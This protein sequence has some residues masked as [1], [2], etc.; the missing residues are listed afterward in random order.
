VAIGQRA[1]KRVCALLTDMSQPLGRAAGNAVEVAECVA[2]LRGGGPEDL[3]QLTLELGARML[4][5]A[6]RASTPDEA[7]SMLEE[8]LRSGAALDRFRHMVHLHG[9][10]TAVLD[11]PSRL[12]SAKIRFEVG[13][14]TSGHVAQANAELIGKACVV[15][16]AGRRTAADGVDPAVG[17]TDIRKVGE[18]VER[19]QPLVVLHSNGRDALTEALPLLEQAFVLS[20]APVT[21]PSLLMESVDGEGGTP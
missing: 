7:R 13:A 14:P 21:A 16:G 1:G 9:G 17:V 8:K 12:P 11:D 5:L 3:R 18:F 19:T 2:T 20:S 4:R 15:L 6:G 10:D